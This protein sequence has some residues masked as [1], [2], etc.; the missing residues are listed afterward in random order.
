[1]K[2]STQVFKFHIPL[3]YKIAVF[4]LLALAA[5]IYSKAARAEL[6]DTY[7]E[8][9]NRFGG[10]GHPDQKRHLIS[11]HESKHFIY[12]AFVKDRGA[13]IVLVPDKG[14]SYTIADAQRILP[15]N[16]GSN[17]LWQPYNAGPNWAVGWSTTD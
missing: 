2:N 16:A 7:S 3:S 17:Q 12:E 13:I 10:K 4:A 1:M 9:C 6:G 15:Y 5:V 8:S 11:W 14:L